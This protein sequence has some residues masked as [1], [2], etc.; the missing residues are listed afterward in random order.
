M[1]LATS[2]SFNGKVT[3][4]LKEAEPD[5]TPEW[6]ASEV[7]RRFGED[8]PWYRMDWR[9]QK[10]QRPTPAQVLSEWNRV[11]PPVAV[12]VDANAERRRRDAE[13][14]AKHPEMMK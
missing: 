9:G 3:A 10:K 7:I 6:I 2:G 4:G 8:G 12:P 5:K 1:T 14:L 11:C 13:I